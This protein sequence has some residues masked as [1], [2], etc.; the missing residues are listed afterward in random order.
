MFDYYAIPMRFPCHEPAASRWQVPSNALLPTPPRGTPASKPL[1]RVRLHFYHF[2]ITFVCTSL[3]LRRLNDATRERF[4]PHRTA[5]RHR[6]HRRPDRALL[7]AVQRRREAAR[8]A[9]CI[10]NL[11]Q[12]GLGAPQLSRRERLIANG[13]SGPLQHGGDVRT[14]QF[15]V[16]RGH[17]PSH[18]AGAAVQRDQLLAGE[19]TVLRSRPAG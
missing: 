10:N 13:T 15:D 4:H 8:R 17:P 11:K 16:G 1:H 5:G 7:P 2:S 19:T 6:D 18:R 9:Q 3:N 14:G 12:I